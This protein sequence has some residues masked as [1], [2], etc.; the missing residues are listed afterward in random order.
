MVFSN[1]SQVTFKEVDDLDT[2]KR[3]TYGFGSTG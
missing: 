2:T 1:V 3:G